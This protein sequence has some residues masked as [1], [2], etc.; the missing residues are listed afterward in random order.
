MIGEHGGQIVDQIT[1]MRHHLIALHGIAR[2]LEQ[3]RSGIIES[4]VDGDTTGFIGHPG[5]ASQTVK[6]T[7][8]PQRSRGQ[9][10]SIG[11][12]PK[13]LREQLG[14]LDRAGIDRQVRASG[15]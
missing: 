8:R 7:Q 4:P 1:T 11:L 13:T 9:Y 6:I 2:N 10:Q 14:G 3:C 15:G 12:S 5:I